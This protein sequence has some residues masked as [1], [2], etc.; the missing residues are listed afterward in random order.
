MSSDDPNLTLALSGS[1]LKAAREASA[2]AAP[3]APE[4][5]GYRLDKL[6]GRGSFGEVWAGL[7]SRTGL[8][9]AVKI[10]TRR[11]GL[12]WLYF[13]HEVGRL[14]E[15]SEH[16]HVVSLIDADL[17]Y[18]PPH[19][20]MPLLS[21]GSLH[22]AERPGFQQAIQWIREIASALRFCHDKGLLH[23]DLKPSNVMLDEEGHVR[24][25]DYGQS[26]AKG[27][28]TVTWGTL[29]FMAPEQA[30]LG[31]E[32]CPT[33]RWDIYSLGATAYYLLTGQCPRLSESDRT[34][35]TRTEDTSRR[36]AQY[37]ELLTRRPL[38]PLRKLNPQV[39][40]DLAAIVESCL[41]LDPDKR[42]DSAEDVLDDLDRRRHGDPL[43]C[44]QPWSLG[45]RLGRALRK[46]KIALS[47]LLVLL[48]VGGGAWAGVTIHRSTMAQFQYDGGVVA[49]QRG[50]LQQAYLRWAE[51]L[52]YV[53]LLMPFKYRMWSVRFNTPLPWVLALRVG[54]PVPDTQGTCLS[55]SPN[56]KFLAAGYENGQV[57]VVKL[58][59]GTL[60]LGPSLKGPVTSVQLDSQGRVLALSARELS[61]E[62]KVR[63]GHW[64]ALTD[65]GE[66]WAVGNEEG[67]ILLVPEMRTLHPGPRSPVERL[68]C[69]GSNLAVVFE[70]DQVMVGPPFRRVPTSQEVKGLAFRD[71]LLVVEL[72]DSSVLLYDKDLR[73]QT[74]AE[75]AR[76]VDEELLS[77]SASSL[78]RIYESVVRV[79]PLA[80]KAHSRNLTH[81]STVRSLAFSQ[82]GTLLATAS[83]DRNVRIWQVDNGAASSSQLRHASQVHALDFNPDGRELAT[84]TRLGVL[85]LWRQSD[86]GNSMRRLE[87]PDQ[88]TV[89]RL[90]GDRLATG[91][92]DG[93]VRVYS[94]SKPGDPLVLDQG[95]LVLALAF[96][97]DARV[98]VSGGVDKSVRVWGPDGQE[99]GRIQTP[100]A[101]TALACSPDGSRLAATCGDKILLIDP[102]TRQVL[103]TLETEDLASDLAFSP[104]GKL[105]AASGVLDGKA[106]VWDAAT[107]QNRYRLKHPGIVPSVDFSADSRW[108]LTSCNDGRARRYDMATG[109][110]LAQAFM[111]EQPLHQALVSPDDHL[112]VV[113]GDERAAQIFHVGD[114]HAGP[115]LAHQD[116]ILDLAFNY[117]GRWVATG[118]QDGTARVWDSYTGMPL[119]SS[120]GHPDQV[121][122]VAFSQDG[123]VLATLSGSVVTLWNL[124]PNDTPAWKL[125]LQTEVDTGQVLD[126]HQVRVLTPEEWQQRKVELD[127]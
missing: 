1:E 57:L 94:L 33:T 71:G 28:T 58:P 104:D 41:E 6:L 13:K 3:V 65:V 45:Y 109:Q 27:D 124:A 42:T 64:T 100:S 10:L 118:S 46:P 56:G 2:D 66:G 105:L 31:G 89:M 88:V 8:R 78:A 16:P 98:L 116:S 4:L 97:K 14:R 73:P 122:Q 35:L 53:P 21:R 20:V 48:L 84:L 50:D 119:T 108:L 76:D 32:S 87:H 95:G 99:M 111:E 22:N 40:K 85:T 90:R 11:E 75:G 77:P 74:E 49:E 43:L 51:A 83:A 121:S 103:A 52:Q 18:D 26:R 15:V 82:D 25:V 17:N 115:L 69:H 47:V 112:V 81:D 117:N 96:S 79:R 102:A 34:E 120:L 62:G 126:G 107:G 36:L 86:T 123:Q 125:Q 106:T 7:Q 59:E 114:N 93:K 67:D 91:C 101:V 23:C 37:R 5:P 70:D 110:E 19:F 61:F 9:V 68:A 63:E 60:S 127:S 54:P 30:V 29:G 39:D 38:V 24:L 92:A 12:D 44:R 113:A 80:D 72:K 55:Y